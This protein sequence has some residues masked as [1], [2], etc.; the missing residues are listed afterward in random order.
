MVRYASG[1]SM[2][3]GISILMLILAACVAPTAAPVTPDETTTAPVTPADAPTAAEAGGEAP[4]LAERVAAGELPPVAE[5]LPA[6]PLVVPVVERI[7]TYGG[8]WNTAL[9]GGQDTSWL[10]RTIGYEFLV[11]VTPDWSE[12]IP[13]VA[14]SY[15]SN[16][17][18]TEFTFHLREG[19][20]WSDGEPFTADDILFWYE[21]VLMNEALTP[22]VPSWL[23]SGE[24]VV[25][26]KIDDFTVVFKFVQPNGLFLPNLASSAGSLPTRYPRHYLEEYHP[27]YNGEVEAQAQAEGF[28]T[29]LQLFESRADVWFNTELPTLNGWVLTTGYEDSTEQV[30]AERNPYYWKVDPEGNQLPY[31]DRVVYDQVQ[32]VEVLVLKALNGEIDMM[33][34]HLATLNNKAVLF[35]NMEAGNYRFFETIP[36]NMNFVIISLNWTHPDPVLREIFQNKDFRIGLS[37]AINRQEILDIVYVGQGEPWQGAPRP[38][39]RFYNERLAKQYTEYDPDLANEYLD[40]A[41]P[42]KN[43]DGIRLGP[44]GEPISFTILTTE[45]VVDTAA[46]ELVRDYWRQVGIQVELQVADRSLVDTRVAANEHDAT[47]WQGSGG[48][49]VMLGPYYYFPLRSTPSRFAI[50]WSNWYQGLPGGEEPPAEAKR[51]MA[52]YDQLKQTADAAEQERLMAEIIEIAADQFYVF[53]IGLDPNGYGIVKNNFHNVPATVPSSNLYLSPAETNPSQYFIE[54]E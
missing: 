7:G 46:L 4:M 11:R 19:M 43:A 47:T 6:N 52:L 14:E 23:V 33:D 12:I 10:G 49:G 44:D 37:H 21:D 25:V 36:T 35:D 2:W 9:L 17:E 38:E 1:K 54:E 8:T 30:V 13:N 48:T 15:E 34:R 24:P 41:Y 42:D 18:A 20:K 53:G 50:A 5:R 40:K 28:D 45:A 31:I 39:S 3:I 22:A 32:N 29:W 26:E 51:Q 27:R 16:A